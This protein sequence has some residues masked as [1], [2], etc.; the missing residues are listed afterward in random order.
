MKTSRIS[1]LLIGVTII[2]GCAS[3]G[4]YPPATSQNYPAPVSTYPQTYPSSQPYYQ[5]YG[6]VDSIQ[7]VQGQGQ[8]A[9]TGNIG[10]GAVVGGVVGGLLGNQIGG[11]RGRKAA[12]VAGVVSGAMIGNEIER[13]S[14]GHDA[15][16]VGVRL[17]NGTHQTIVQD[18]AADLQ[19]GTRVRVENNR[20]VRYY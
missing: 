20:V 3:P 8:N 1:V 17:D 18:S 14:P 5:S 7:L 9:T 2:A 11:G 16:Q 6:T 13:N 10:V 4:Y 19:I 12:T 15:Y